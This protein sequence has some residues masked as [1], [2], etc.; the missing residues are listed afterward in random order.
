MS[1]TGFAEQMGTR[2]LNV[3]EN[4]TSNILNQWQL[5]NHLRNVLGFHSIFFNQTS[6]SFREKSDLEESLHFYAIKHKITHHAITVT[7]RSIGSIKN[8]ASE[9]KSLRIL[10]VDDTFTSNNYYTSEGDH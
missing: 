3:M 2:I 7:P 1:H 5:E 9:N 4:I 6:Q 8:D 10:H